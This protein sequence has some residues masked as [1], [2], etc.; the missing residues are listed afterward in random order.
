MEEKQTHVIDLGEVNSKE[1]SDQ[2]KQMQARLM[3]RGTEFQISQDHIVLQPVNVKEIERIL[4]EDAAIPSRVLK[5]NLKQDSKAMFEIL[6]M[7]DKHV[8]KQ[9]E[10]KEIEEVSID[11]NE[12]QG[13]ILFYFSDS[14]CMDSVVGQMEKVMPDGFHIIPIPVAKGSER[15]E[16]LRL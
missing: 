12:T 15:V 6:N 13:L 16:L 2:I 5:G 9:E 10:E 4:E 7:W 11:R 14:N 3:D 8:K 1:A